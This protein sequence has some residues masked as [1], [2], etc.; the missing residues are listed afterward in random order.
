MNQKIKLT[1]AIFIAA[2]LLIQLIRP[3]KN[4]SAIR[5]GKTFVDSFQVDRQ[6]DSLLSVSCYDCHSNNTNYPWYSS[7]QPAGWLMAN[8]IKDGKGEL[9]FDELP[10]Y[11]IRKIR[12]KANQISSQIRDEEM[13]LKSYLLLHP[14]ARLSSE[15]RDILIKYF[16]SLQRR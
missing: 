1:S 4:T 9:N 5:G 16:N 2:I 10:T 6:V 14:A 12:S 7:I 3:S 13:P 15:E 8:H 11:T